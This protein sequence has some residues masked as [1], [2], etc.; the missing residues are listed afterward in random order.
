MDE[1]DHL[2][3]AVATS[4][5]ENA[6]REASGRVR[7][8]EKADRATVEQA[9]DPRTR[10]VLFKMLNQGVFSEINGCISTGKEANVY[11]ASTADD[12]ELA[13]KVYK[14]S[15]LVF[16]DR[17]RYVTGDWRFRNGYCKHNPRKMVR[18]WAEK[19]M[20]NLARLREAGIFA[21]EPRML[22]AHVLVM[23]FL[24]EGGYPAPRLKARFACVLVMAG[25]LGGAAHSPSLRKQDAEIPASRLRALYTQ[26]VMD[27]RT[28][29]QRCRLV[30]ADLSEYNLLYHAGR[31][32]IIDVSQSVDLDHPRCFDFLREDLTHVND[33]FGKKGVATATERELFDF[34]TDPTISDANVD[35]C[36]DRLSAAADARAAEGPGCVS[37][38]G[39]G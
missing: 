24:G 10:L 19:E 34:V 28:M 1:C 21:P 5:R 12:H 8:S 13:V 18:T 7:T 35:A 33:F 29:F 15:I 6:R 30:H 26:L 17:D 37:S 22:R 36:L 11:H 3:S 39:W 9:L 31:L 2:P 14:T 27:V 20:R 38:K 4:V 32:A 25:W 16:K 23:D